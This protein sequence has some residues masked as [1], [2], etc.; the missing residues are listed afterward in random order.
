MEIWEKL[1]YKSDM[2]Y[3]KRSYAGQKGEVKKFIVPKLGPTHA[4][5]AIKRPVDPL[6]GH[7]R[8][9]FK[10]YDLF[11]NGVIEKE[12]LVDND[13]DEPIPTLDEWFNKQRKRTTHFREYINYCIESCQY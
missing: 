3:F 10:I 5:Y 9:E 11:H 12:V 1:G 13:S 4:F 6:Y 7:E 2:E 8:Y